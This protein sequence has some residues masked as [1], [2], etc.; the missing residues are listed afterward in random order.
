MELKV[1]QVVHRPISGVRGWVWRVDYS[2][3][4]DERESVLFGARPKRSN[5]GR[6]EYCPAD[7]LLEHPNGTVSAIR[8]SVNTRFLAEDL[9]R[10][11]QS[12]GL[13]AVLPGLGFIKLFEDGT[14]RLVREAGESVKVYF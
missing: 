11:A 1:V 4:A 5:P 14:F 8:F 3:H 13:A 9:V 12:K 2:T 7:L 6:F 10:S